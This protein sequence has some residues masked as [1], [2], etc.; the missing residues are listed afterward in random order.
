MSNSKENNNNKK[1]IE[2]DI[3]SMLPE[4]PSYDDMQ[5]IFSNILRDMA[6][7][8]SED[9]RKQEQQRKAEVAAARDKF[10]DSVLEYY[11]GIRSIYAEPPSKEDLASKKN[12]LVTILTP[13]AEDFEKATM[14]LAKANNEK[15]SSKNSLIDEIFNNIFSFPI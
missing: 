13:F 7:K 14:D 3:K 5:R 15:G 2:N 4:G 6:K 1:K 10:F 11:K 8:E 12:E 9:L